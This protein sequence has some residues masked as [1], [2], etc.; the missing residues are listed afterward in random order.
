[1]ACGCGKRSGVEFTTGVTSS[2][3]AED[4]VGLISL[5]SAPDCTE[6]YHGVFIKSS[7]VVM[8]R[9]TENEK[10]FRRGDQ[11]EARHTAVKNGWTLDHV[12][13]DQLC[14]ES[15]VQLFGA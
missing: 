15:V 13:A 9:D 3:P 14:H 11:V 2:L 4:E 8:A 5:A 10:L 1:M 6:K 7:V 12:R